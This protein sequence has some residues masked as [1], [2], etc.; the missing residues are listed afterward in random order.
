MIANA[1]PLPIN[2]FE[3]MKAK[4]QTDSLPKCDKCR[5]ILLHCKCPE[6]ELKK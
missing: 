4:G 3:W 5:K 1:P 6:K 2:P